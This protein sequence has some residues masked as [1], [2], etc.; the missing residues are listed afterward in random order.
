LYYRRLS[1]L[2][3]APEVVS[4]DSEQIL[5]RWHEPLHCWRAHHSRDEWIDM[6]LRV[7]SRVKELHSH[8]VCHRDLHVGN[9]VVQ[10]GQP[11]FVDMEFAAASDP[12]KP[13]YDLIG[14]E[15]SG[16]SVPRRHAEQPNANQ[17]GVWWDAENS[18][19]KTLGHAFGS[20][21]DLSERLANL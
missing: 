11:L 20:L 3:L 1:N 9:I 5:A 15:R 4:A 2:G 13:C 16:V 21:Q 8:G 6:G 12:A 14:P 19:V 7:F 10:D 17:H 18:E